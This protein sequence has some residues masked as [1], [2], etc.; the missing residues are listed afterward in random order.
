[1]LRPL[2]TLTTDFG[3]ADH[4]VAVM[5]AVILSLCPKAAIVDISHETPAF[6][7]TEGAFILA[8]AYRW[9]PKKTIHVAVIDPGVGAARRP[10]LLEAAGQYFLAPDNGLLTLVCRREKHRAREVASE[11]FFLKPVSQTFHGRDVFA[12]CAAHLANGT[13]P[14]RFGKLINDHFRL[15]IPEPAQTG[16]RV[17]TG[18][19]LKIDR[20]GNLITNFP[21]EEFQRISARPFEMAVGMEKVTRLARNYAEG[22]T[23][24]VFLIAGSSGY[25]EVAANQASAAKLLGCGVGAPAELTIW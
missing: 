4:F 8:E 21:F 15:F 19:V 13:P 11:R 16:K 20:F 18:A 9:F 24:E 25:L 14:G 7:I 17:W 22:A 12:P 6:D 5:K 10:I 3:R 2:I 1:M 23:G